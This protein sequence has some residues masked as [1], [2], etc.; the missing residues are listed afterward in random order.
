MIEGDGRGR[1]RELSTSCLQLF[2]ERK[3]NRLRIEFFRLQTFEMKFRLST[4]TLWHVFILPLCIAA[5]TVV[6][7]VPSSKLRTSLT[8]S[9]QRNLQSDT[10]LWDISPPTYSYSGMK[11][12]LEH[13]VR[14]QVQPSNVR[15]DLFRDEACSIALENNNYITTDVISD[16]TNPGDGSGTRQVRFRVVLCSL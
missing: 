8:R 3:K 12:G 1:R 9:V 10:R 4:M 14:D 15:I 7:H 5:T 2:K 16:L 11:L 6:D 13:T